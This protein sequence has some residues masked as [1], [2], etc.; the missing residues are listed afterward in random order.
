MEVQK[1]EPE[2]AGSQVARVQAVCAD[3]VIAVGPWRRLAQGLDS[4]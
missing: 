3:T 2:E 1:Y 4:S